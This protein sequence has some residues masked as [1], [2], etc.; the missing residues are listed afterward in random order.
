MEQERSDATIFITHAP[1]DDAWVEGALRPALER[2]GVVVLSP[3]DFE[4]GRPWLDAAEAAITR[5]RLTVLV[6]SPAYRAGRVQEVVDL[7]AQSHNV[8]EGRWPVVPLIRRPTPLPPRLAMLVPL[9]ATTPTHAAEA[10]ERLVDMVGGTAP[11]GPGP[12][13]P[14]PYPGMV[15]FQEADR[16]RFYG[17]DAEIADAL[18]RLRADPFLT[19]IGPSGSGKSSLV[20]AGIIPALRESSLFGEGDWQV[21]VVR[22][23]TAAFAALD[24]IVAGSGRRLLVVDQFEESFALPRTDAAT[25][26]ETL[27]RLIREREVM[28]I[29]TVRADYFDD[30]MSERTLW[31]AISSH[32]L[33]LPPLSRDG[34]R[35]AIVRPAAQVGVHLDDALVE[36][37][38]GDAGDEPGILPML[39]ETLVRLWDALDERYL[40]IE[41]YDAM[42]AGRSGRSGLDIAME[43]HAERAITDLESADR[44][45]AR[46]LFLRLITFGEG[47]PH[48][49]RRERLDALLSTARDP[50]RARHVV[51]HLTARRLLV[52][53]A[54]DDGTEWVDLAHEALIRGWP[55]LAEWIHRDLARELQ[56]RRYERWVAE[57]KSNVRGLLDPPS[58][59][60]LETWL[61]D[62]EPGE[63]LSAYRELAEES[64]RRNE[65][66]RWWSRTRRVALLALPVL[67]IGL[68]VWVADAFE[69]SQDERA[70]QAV[71]AGNPLLGHESWPFLIEQYE[72]RNS[73]YCD[74]VRH[75]GCDEI[76]YREDG[77]S[78]CDAEPNDP[79][80][81]VTFVQAR[82][83]CR[84]ID[85]RLPAQ[86]EWQLA[87]R[88]V[89]G[90]PYPTGQTRPDPVDINAD[91]AGE[92]GVCP[93]EA[94]VPVDGIPN[95]VTPITG[96]VGMSGN[97]SEWVA[98][99]DGEAAGRLGSDFCS[100]VDAAHTDRDPGSA[101][102]TTFV[103][104][105]CAADR[106]LDLVK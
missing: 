51:D 22:P 89:D 44:E 34:L 1:A 11:L 80:V 95:D 68:F 46:R 55:R 12:P 76:V 23:G 29:L 61:D 35:D 19:V 94:L 67:A 64:R 88:G 37:L 102:A 106:P 40:G 31:N 73:H 15:P 13:I 9:D 87:A 78:V 30:L 49:R 70:R 10:I 16:A 83:Y 20:L 98:G 86:G 101:D 54:D 66:E 6:L 24:E 26:R 91:A 97:V 2:A 59:R 57:W 90:N 84:W 85:R 41:A 43:H 96:I 50:D 7:I 52:Q 74:C 93:R 103:G 71:I 79:V 3:A 36:R 53:D 82:T 18:T 100:S 4:P 17:R 72:V 81:E 77:V 104:F 27:A 8:A 47:R 39:Q 5:S 32:R 14:C 92:A 62:A 60:G 42:V 75:D 58:L 33:E 63:D 28:L 105:R 48:T 21:R 99:P 69:S 38:L 25:L 56:R 65:R 45:V